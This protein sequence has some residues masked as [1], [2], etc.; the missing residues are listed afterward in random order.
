MPFEC[1]PNLII[2]EKRAE[3]RFILSPE[4][5]TEKTSAVDLSQSKLL[6]KKLVGPPAITNFDELRRKQGPAKRELY[7]AVT[8][9]RFNCPPVDFFPL[10]SGGWYFAPPNLGI[11]PGYCL[12][13]CP[14]PAGETDAEISIQSSGISTDFRSLNA[15]L[16]AFY[17]TVYKAPPHALT[18]K[19][20]KAIEEDIAE[21]FS[22][23][24]TYDLNGKRVLELCAHFKS[25]NKDVYRL[26]FNLKEDNC[27]ELSIVTLNFQAKPDKFCKYIKAVKHCFSQIQWSTKSDAPTK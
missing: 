18:A 19:E 6:A 9:A 24:R 17:E 7:K 11:P 14:A 12:A 16:S 1:P 8:A 22:S 26:E 25:E 21:E 2:P 13:F 10:P 4:S 23:A 27:Q 15:P 20:I 3:I 5:A